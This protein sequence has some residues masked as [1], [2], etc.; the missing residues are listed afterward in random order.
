MRSPCLVFALSLIGACHGSTISGQELQLRTSAYSIDPL[1]A[2][3]VDAKIPHTILTDHD[4]QESLVEVTLREGTRVMTTTR[5]I[6]VSQYCG[7]RDTTLVNAAVTTPVGSSADGFFVFYSRI[8]KEGH[9]TLFKVN[10]N[11]AKPVRLSRGNKDSIYICVPSVSDNLILADTPGF[12][13][14]EVLKGVLEIS[15]E[16]FWRVVNGSEIESS[17]SVRVFFITVARMCD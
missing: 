8:F 3:R 7:A 16:K 2:K 15:S 6:I 13:K 4:R 10:G 9:Q 11:L 1:V 5:R 14:G 17:I 12:R